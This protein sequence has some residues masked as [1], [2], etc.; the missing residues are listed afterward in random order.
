[1]KQTPLMTQMEGQLPPETI[2]GVSEKANSEQINDDI[3]TAHNCPHM[4][5]ELMIESL[6]GAPY[7]RKLTLQDPHLFFTSSLPLLALKQYPLNC[8]I[9]FTL[10]CTSNLKQPKNGLFSMK[11]E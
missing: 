8:C 1:M 4:N 11:A 3:S 9:I 5:N 7:T 10:R 6:T 2:N